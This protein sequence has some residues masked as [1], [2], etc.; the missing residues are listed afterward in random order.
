MIDYQLKKDAKLSLFNKLWRYSGI[1]ALWCSG[2]RESNY[3]ESPG[4]ISDH[5]GLWFFVF[6]FLF[7]NNINC[8]EKG[9]KNFTSI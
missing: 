3:S 5:F 6:L 1:R 9:K 4:S 8:L 7:Y 2:E